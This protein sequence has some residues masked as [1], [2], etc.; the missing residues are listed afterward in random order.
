MRNLLLSVALIAA[1]VAAFALVET[2][3]LAPPTPAGATVATAPQA[4]PNANGLGD[5]TAYAAIVTDTQSL[6]AKGDLGAAEHRITDLETLWDTNA[7]ALRK[8]DPG[9]WGAIDGAADATF[10]ALRAWTPD[11]A[12]VG[13]TLAALQAT[14]AAP[15]AAPAA[16]TGAAVRQVA[17]IDVT[18]ASGHALPCEE[19]IGKLRATLG[20]SAAPAGVADLQAKAL[21]RCNA[22][23]DTRADAFAAQALAQLKG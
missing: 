15:Q 6:A 19:M 20:A 16:P 3:L 12:Q 9:A 22:D 10:S 13:A 21:E 8:A 11:P 2:T 1:P 5:L 18:D 14:L 4:A 23:D 17:G 7:A